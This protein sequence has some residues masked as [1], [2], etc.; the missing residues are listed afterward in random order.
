MFTFL[1]IHNLD[2]ESIKHQILLAIC[3]FIFENSN[4]SSPFYTIISFLYVYKDM[5]LLIYRSIQ[6]M[7]SHLN[8]LYIIFM[9]KFHA[10]QNYDY[11]KVLLAY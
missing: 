2:K 5:H 10:I 11:K 7:L 3:C 1:I 4:V 6:H 8:L 9:L